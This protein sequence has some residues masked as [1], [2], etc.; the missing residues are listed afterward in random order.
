MVYFF[1]LI[2]INL[3]F[4]FNYIYKISSLLWSS[5][6]YSRETE[7][8]DWE[9]SRRYYWLPGIRHVTGITLK[10]IR[11]FMTTL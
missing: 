9:K 4:L 1:K 2:N 3:Y 10:E 6:N 8:F 5:V 7:S 11:G